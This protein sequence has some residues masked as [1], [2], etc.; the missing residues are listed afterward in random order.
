MERSVVLARDARLVGKRIRVHWPDDDAWYAGL[1]TGYSSRR[2]HCVKYDHVP[3]ESDRTEYED[4]EDLVWE[5][6]NSYEQQAQTAKDS[7]ETFCCTPSLATG[8]LEATARRTAAAAGPVRRQAAGS[9][10]APVRRTAA[11]SATRSLAADGSSIKRDETAVSAPEVEVSHDSDVE[12]IEGPV[13]RSQPP[14]GSSSFGGPIDSD[15]DDE[16]VCMGHTGE[17]ALQ[18]FPH[19]REN[20][21]AIQF[22]RGLEQK[23]CILCYCFV[24][25][26]LAADCE[27]WQMHAKALAKSP[28]WQRQRTAA[29]VA[30]DA[31]A[32]AAAAAKAAVKKA[33]AEKVAVGKL[34]AMSAEALKVRAAAKAAANQANAVTVAAD[35]AERVATDAAVINHGG[36]GPSCE[37]S[38]A[39]MGE[40]TH[41]RPIGV[42]R[43]Y[44]AGTEF[45]RIRRALAFQHECQRLLLIGSQLCTLLEPRGFRLL[46]WVHGA[47]RDRLED[48]V[49]APS[50]RCGRGRLVAVRFDGRFSSGSCGHPLAL[51]LPP[52]AY[53]FLAKGIRLENFGNQLENRS[54]GK[55]AASAPIDQV[56][57]HLACPR[58]VSEALELD[59]HMCTLRTTDRS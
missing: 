9:S 41:R 56:F 51:L 54:L 31:A 59:T 34:K 10:K 57:D 47:H 38:A 3:G 20:C 50:G 24:C 17:L 39:A 27:Q 52:Y 28:Y 8:N 49:T 12:E 36:A 40:G 48:A 37:R 15:S 35:K 44:P 22:A 23:H 4:L 58:A 55:D 18:D 42:V 45:L 30:K 25:D 29:R 11:A 13:R 46:Q 7:T 1:I 26:G 16:L 21:V 33:A 2:G 32:E 53:E 14:A 5:F 6:E 43:A 19:A